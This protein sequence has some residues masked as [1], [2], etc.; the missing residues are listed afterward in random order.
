MSNGW[1]IIPAIFIIALFIVIR[2]YYLRSARDVKRLEA[3]GK[4]DVLRIVLLLYAMSIFLSM[5]CEIGS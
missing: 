5:D 3:L 4:V 2:W 1:L